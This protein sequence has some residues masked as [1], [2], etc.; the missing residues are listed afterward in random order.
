MKD[1]V[2]LGDF[3]IGRV[4]LVVGSVSTAATMDRLLADPDPALDVVELRLDL[5]GN[6]S[7]D[8][9]EKASKL[10]RKGLPV[11]LT[12]RHSAE[13][14]QWGGTHAERQALYE[15]AL[16]WVSAVDCEIDRGGLEAVA[17]AAHAA[18]RVVI[19]SFHD[20]Q[21]TPDIHR[22]NG[23]V[24]EG[25]TLGADIVKLATA[26]LADQDEQTLLDVMKRRTDVHFCL[27]G[28]GSRGGATRIRFALAGSCLVY[29]YVD[30][31]VAPG[32]PSA[33]ELREKLREQ[34]PAYREF[35]AA[36]RPAS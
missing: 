23:F 10:E 9:L 36:R 7:D 5:M 22:L 21:K 19:G 27:L 32:Q 24:R 29:G 20:F 34:S 6:E 16:P 13:G 8:W 3:E 14:G 26:I 31:P 28:M 33:A 1:R 25:R 30:Q 2:R 35:T 11:I 12:L 4:P 17:T 15:Q 18:R